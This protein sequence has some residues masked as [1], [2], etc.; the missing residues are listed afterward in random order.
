MRDS[1]VR[2]GRLQPFSNRCLDKTFWYPGSWVLYATKQGYQLEY[3]FSPSP[4][5]RTC[6]AG[7]DPPKT[8][9]G[10][11]MD[12]S[13]NFHRPSVFSPGRSIVYL[14]RDI[15]C[16]ISSSDMEPGCIRCCMAWNKKTSAKM[17]MD[18]CSRSRIWTKMTY[19]QLS[20]MQLSDE[21]WDFPSK[22]SFMIVAL[23]KYD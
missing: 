19:T 16:W 4:T 5:G 23:F 11:T 17:A 21:L 18:T 3:W 22:G 2:T 14:R 7:A 13:Q 6:C 8:Q 10:F 9:A 15:M 12:G 1:H 20:L